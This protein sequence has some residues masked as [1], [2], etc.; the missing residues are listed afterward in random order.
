MVTSR[1]SFCKFSLIPNIGV[2]FLIATHNSTFE[3]ITAITSSGWALLFYSLVSCALRRDASEMPVTA[4]ATSHPSFIKMEDRKRSATQDDLAPPTKRQAVNGSKA[5]ADADM[6][7]K[8]DLEVSYIT[9]HRS[10]S[11]NTSHIPLSS[12][13]Q[14]FRSQCFQ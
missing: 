5:S 2:F 7:W 9:R 11:I 3:R 6:P 8:D 14:A 13:T 1:N 10:C 12:F 4:P